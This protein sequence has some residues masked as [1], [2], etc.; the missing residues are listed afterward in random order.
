M[1][2][3]SLPGEFSSYSSNIQR[4]AGNDP[5]TVRSMG[6]ARAKRR[7]DG[8]VRNEA[9]SRCR[10]SSSTTMHLSIKSECPHVSSEDDSLKVALCG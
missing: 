4:R 5:V 1:K 3:G 7:G 10:R 9:G 2:D 8:V 6:G